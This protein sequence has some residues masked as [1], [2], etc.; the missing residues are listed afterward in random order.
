[1]ILG[2]LTQNSAECPPK[3]A[4]LGPILADA[5]ARVGPT[6]VN[7]WPMFVGVRRPRITPKMP[8]RVLFGIGNARRAAWEHLFSSCLTLSKKGLLG[9]PAT[10]R[11]VP[12]PSLGGGTLRCV[13]GKPNNPVPFHDA[14]FASNPS[15]RPLSFL[16]L[17]CPRETYGN[18]ND[19][20]NSQC[21]AAAQKP[22]SL[23]INTAP[24]GLLPLS[25]QADAASH[26]VAK[27][28]LK[29]ARRRKPKG[30]RKMWRRGMPQGR[31]E[32]GN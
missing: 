13:A 12:P 30:R 24:G 1:M 25:P 22:S 27:R 14:P 3:L 31:M 5:L 29:P 10:Q 8:P 9:F 26:P 18:S 16:S 11:K 2:R 4:Q 23:H 19:P 32:F 28:R 21:A 6:L 17:R 20:A 7:M 15:P